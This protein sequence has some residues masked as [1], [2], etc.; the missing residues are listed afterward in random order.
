MGGY[1]RTSPQNT[2]PET[3]SQANAPENGW[4]WSWKDFFG[5]FPFGWDFGP[6]CSGAIYIWLLYFQENHAIQTPFTLGGS[7][8]PVRP[9]S[10]I[11]IIPKYANIYPKH[12][13]LK[14][15]TE[16]YSTTVVKKI[17]QGFGK[18]IHFVLFWGHIK[19]YFPGAFRWVTALGVVC[20]AKVDRAK[21]V[22]Y[23]RDPW[24]DSMVYSDPWIRWM[25]LGVNYR[26]MY[27][28]DQISQMKIHSQ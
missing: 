1:D 23:L 27:R 18:M 14:N 25:F 17:V 11:G 5:P 26:S 2:I 28:C 15:S 19:A 4:D 16:Y 24:W 13:Q 7:L 21:T 10:A 20:S 6:K 3:N 8:K 22:K 12:V 9:G